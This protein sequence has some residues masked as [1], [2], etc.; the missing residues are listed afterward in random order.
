MRRELPPAGMGGLP[1]AGALVLA[2]AGYWL[3]WLAHPAAAL[4]LNA[5]ELSE[6]VT[7]LPG[8]QLGELPFGRLTFLVPSAC[9]ALLFALAAARMRRAPARGW[10]TAL[11]PDSLWS[12][13]LLTL[14]LL[15]AIT[16][17]PYY[18]YFLTAYNDPE[19][20]LQFWLACAVLL[21]LP[22]ALWLP[23]HLAGLFQLA[24]AL[25]GLG[26][27]VWALWSLWPI[28]TELLGTTWPIGW[29]WPATLLG[30]V[31]ALVDGWR[32]L[33]QPRYYSR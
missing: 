28:A 31:G 23:D 2:L 24:L 16:V 8:V 11:L 17:F 30:F 14:A 6:W 3:P 15:S 25:I 12:W 7:F 26:F 18:P 29:G 9:L 19:F 27:S 5:Y 32:V 20:G 13:G 33:F 10:V 4:Q 21:G 1:L 22:F